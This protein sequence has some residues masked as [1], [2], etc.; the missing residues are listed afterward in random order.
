MGGKGGGGGMPG[1]YPVWH[2]LQ[3]EKAAKEAA[4]AAAAAAAAA[5]KPAPVQAA[6]PT[7]TWTPPPAEPAPQGS[8]NA[9]RPDALGAPISTGGAVTGPTAANNPA[10]AGTGGIGAG[11]GDAV[12]APPKYWVGGSGGTSAAAPKTG[13]GQ[14]SVK[15]GG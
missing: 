9:P 12:M 1:W 6:A 4:D 2:K 8:A 11:L 5:N 3:A 14:G 10:T 7:P 15:S 13:R